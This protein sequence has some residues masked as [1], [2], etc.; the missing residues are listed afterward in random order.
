MATPT[1]SNN[2]SWF[3]VV[4]QFNMGK[5]QPLAI[6]G[7]QAD[8]QTIQNTLNEAQKTIQNYE[9]KNPM[10]NILEVQ[11]EYNDVMEQEYNYLQNKERQIRMDIETGERIMQLNDS[12]RKKYYAYVSIVII[13]VCVIVLILLLVYLNRYLGIPFNFF[14]AVIVTTAVLWSGWI[15]YTISLR[16]PTDYDKLNLEP[17]N[18]GPSANAG[19][20]LAGNNLFGT[21]NGPTCV[22]AE[23]CPLVSAQ[24]YKMQY[25]PLINKCEIVMSQGPSPHADSFVGNKEGFVTMSQFLDYYPP[26]SISKLFKMPLYN[27]ACEGEEY[28]TYRDNTN[29]RI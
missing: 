11:T 9:I 23:C 3:D 4:S 27:Y 6:T 13:W 15:L 7:T 17:P 26:M 28:C 8:P 10:A 19:D 29:S 20:L 14:F 21:N 18:L 16:D 12:N 2:T 5:T 24:G 1:L 25:N 22:G